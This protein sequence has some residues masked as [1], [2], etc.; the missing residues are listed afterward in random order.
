MASSVLILG[1]G[2]S[3]LL[4][5][6]FID[7]FGGELWVANYAYRRYGARCTRV[8]GHSN[9]MDEAAVYRDQHGLN[10]KIMGRVTDR[11]ECSITCPA[12]FRKD[13]GTTMVAQA[14]EEGYDVY[15]CGFDLG[16]PDVLSLNLHLRNKR[17]WVRRWK[18]IVD[19]YGA[20][21]IHFVGHD[22]LPVIVLGDDV[23]YA[24]RYRKGL[25]HI[26]DPEYIALHRLIYGSHGAWRPEH[27]VKVR[28]IKKNPGFETE[29]RESIA[30]KLADK[31]VVEI[32]GK[33]RQVEPGVEVTANTQVT[34][35][36]SKETLVEVAKLRGIE[37]AEEITKTELLSLL[38]GAESDNGQEPQE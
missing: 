13:S 37:D 36:M 9:V 16:G 21:R 24:R 28:Y 31:G 26:P 18:A 27:V 23:S 20:E 5:D 3:R 12:E 29:Y 34:T 15:L 25:P 4:H 10:F 8:C 14:L 7:S 35:R 11:D 30:M 33:P 38:K 22:H 19:R 17:S 6:D 32:I 1:N 2:I